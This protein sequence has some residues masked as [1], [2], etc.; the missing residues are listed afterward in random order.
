MNLASYDAL[1]VRLPLVKTRSLHL[2]TGGSQETSYAR[3]V[4][5][6]RLMLYKNEFDSTS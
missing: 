4:R 3:C 1:R 2:P 5:M 6:P